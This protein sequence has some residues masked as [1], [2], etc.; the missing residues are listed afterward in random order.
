IDNYYEY[1]TTSQH[2]LQPILRYA[3][4]L[5]MCAE[6]LNESGRTTEAIPYIN[7]V[8]ARPGVDMPPLTTDLNQEELREKIRHE[9]QI[10]LNFEEMRYHDIRRWG[11]AKEVSEGPLYGAKI[12]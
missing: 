12:T 4:L 2:F 5:L 11:I 3:D 6:A 10:E 7:E 9:R 1:G 8:R